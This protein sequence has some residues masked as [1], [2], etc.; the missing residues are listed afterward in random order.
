MEN[1]KTKINSRKLILRLSIILLFIF[2]L[3]FL[4][5]FYTHFSS[6]FSGAIYPH[7]ITQQWHIVILN[8]VIFLSFLIPLYFRRKINW[9]EFGLVT[10][11]IVSLFVEMYGIPLTVFFASKYLVGGNVEIPNAMFKFEFLGVDI[12][13]THAMFYGMVLMII[14]MLLIIVGWLTLFKNLKEN[15]IVT[16]GIYAYS[17]HPQY[18][19][20]I[21]I[22]L[23]WLVGWPTILT[24]IFAPIL[25]FMYVRVC[26]HEE[27]E[28]GDSPDYE[29]Y[30]KKVPF[31]V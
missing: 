1:S 21:L 3:F 30:K 16:K 17:R 4:R 2:P 5:E 28:L 19:G 20:F 6:H 24:L 25:I 23:G 29:K 14:G 10:A 26:K 7:V 13:V 31:F 22:V 9:K 18:L 27:K 15:E 8:I 12:Y 11:F